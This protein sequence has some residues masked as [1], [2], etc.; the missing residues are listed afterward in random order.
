MRPFLASLALLFVFTAVS[1]CATVRP[2]DEAVS[3]PQS[4]AAAFARPSDSLL[5]RP[6]LQ[7]VVE[8]QTRRDSAALRAFLSD[9]DPAVRARAALAIGSVQDPAAVPLLLGLLD[10]RDPRVRA[11][12]AFAL[13]QS[14]DTTAALRLIDALRAET[15]P[16]VQRL[17]LEALGK[18]GGAATLSALPTLDLPGLDAG[19]ALAIAR[20]GLRGVFDRD[21]TDWLV[22][23]LTASELEVRQ[24][25]AYLFGRIN[26]PE[27]WRYAADR[28]LAASDS[29]GASDPA[30]QYLALA[31]G[32]M[33]SSAGRVQLVEL[34]QASD[35][36]RVRTNA[37]RALTGSTS[38]LTRDALLR[39]LDD[40]STHVA[41]TAA[42]A[43][44]AADS[45][46]AEHLDGIE[47]A[48]ERYGLTWQIWTALLPSL[49]RNGRLET[50]LLW[51]S[52]VVPQPALVPMPQ[53][54]SV[55]R[56]EE[57]PF[58]QAAALAGLASVTDSTALAV[59]ARESATD[60][61]RVAYAAVEALKASWQAERSAE[62]APFYFPLFAA[63]LERRD[64]ATA[65][66]A[67]P[68]L[69]DSLF[70]PLGASDVLRNTYAAMTTPDDIEPMVEIVRALGEIR[71]TTAV[72]FLLEVAI[73]GPHPT[74]R[75][76]AAETLSERFGR[77]IDFEATGLA[78]PDF[79]KIDWERLRALGRHPLLTL[80]TDRGTVVLELD[81]EAAP[82]TVDAIVRNAEADRYDG[83]PFHRVVPNFV[84]QGGDYVRADGFGG[85]GY[86][87]PSEF[88]R[89]PY[90]RGTV[91][92]ASAGKDT[93]GSQFFVTHSM[94]PHLDGRYT[95][96]GRVVQ[97][98]DVVDAIR[99]GDRVVRASVQPAPGLESR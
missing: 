32:R 97:G 28:L 52:G 20:Y 90:E 86:F 39:A 91:G 57:L 4:P 27:P 84:I 60:D 50:A 76:A 64:L 51:V 80:E 47:A 83:V 71:D 96:F 89:I 5:H 31:L 29:L 6:D 66:A 8:R 75:T 94:Q 16:A 30:Q 25:A 55:E 56:L 14:A 85:P 7:A 35:D 49:V 62:R 13:D 38:D 11:D 10:D 41:V 24:N 61:P 68:A 36:W 34:L 72:P 93:E 77:G 18:T 26:D 69:A 92:M 33:E 12:A 45:L 37:A 48:M 74:I 65:Y 42:G 73:E 9:D 54:Y 3:P 98:Q 95:A 78:P 67:A 21:A 2:A 99:Q 22:N 59:L 82:V 43:L 58:A 46:S 70:R 40:P 1:G 79:P 53:G 19:R 87:L 44:A 63:A 88:A 17:L 15:D 23:H 81:A